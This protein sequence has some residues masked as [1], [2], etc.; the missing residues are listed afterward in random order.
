MITR[1]CTQV[2]ATLVALWTARKVFFC[3]Q[4]D[5]RFFFIRWNP[6]QRI[7]FVPCIPPLL[8]LWPVVLAMWLIRLRNPNP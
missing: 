4:R 7:L 6:A 8:F 3:E 5:S 1:F 2:V